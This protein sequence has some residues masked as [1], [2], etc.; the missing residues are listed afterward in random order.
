MTSWDLITPWINKTKRLTII[1]CKGANVI[2]IW[3]VIKSVVRTERPVEKG[4]K[5]WFNPNTKQAYKLTHNNSKLK[6]T[7]GI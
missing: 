2:S 4:N 5:F 6:T 7:Q 3:I 1:F